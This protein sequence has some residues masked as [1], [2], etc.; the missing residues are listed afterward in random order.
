MKI[1]LIYKSKTGFTKRYAEWICEEINCRLEDI[2]NIKN[3]N[4][5]SY[6]LVIYGSRI[7]AGKI[8]GIDKIKKLN[9][10]NKLILFVTGATPKETNSIKEV[11]KNNLTEEEYKTIK[12]F[13]IPAGLNYEKMGFL[14]KMMMK[15]ASMML[16]KKQDKSAE[17]ID[18][19]NFIKKSYDISNKARIKPLVEYIKSL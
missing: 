10:E 12:H 13:Y 8:D 19:Q 18:M 5:N 6:D 7:H 17:D 14:D 4:F 11:W 3:I 16:E 1:L 15:M 9:L 2:S